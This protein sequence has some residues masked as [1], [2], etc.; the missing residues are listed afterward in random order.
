VL[1]KSWE[2]F[3]I[4]NILSVLP[5]QAEAWFYRTS[6]GAEIDLL[7]K[8]PGQELWAIEIKSGVAPKI[9]KGFHLACKD[10]KATRKYVIYGGEDEFPI[11]KDTTVLSLK[12]MLVKLQ[13]YS[14][15]R[16]IAGR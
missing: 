15:E 3:A 14:R 9:T 11:A 2:G 13:A 16:S 8:L 10:V 1:G 6:A 5:D 12:G 4:E 7:I